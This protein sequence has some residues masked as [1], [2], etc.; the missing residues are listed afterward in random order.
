MLS[1][2]PAFAELAAEPAAKPTAWFEFGFWDDFQLFGP[3]VA[4]HGLRFNLGA[5]ENREMRGVDLF[6]LGNLT[7]GDQIGTQLGFYNRVG[8]DLGGL[9]LAIF[10][11]EV[12]GRTCALQAAGL[13]NRAGEVGGG[14]IATF[15][16]RAKR[17]R[18]FQIGLVNDAGDL[19]GLQIGLV[20]VVR[21]GWI[22]VF[23]LLNV[24]PLR[25]GASAPGDGSPAAP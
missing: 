25:R 24:G 21:N 14:Q 11:S 7:S 18:G 8:G 10:A 17:V 4:I 19:A 3:D 5:A 9:Q 22:P 15:L 13:T 2:G 20:N 16:N 1:G 23:P 6:G 12:E